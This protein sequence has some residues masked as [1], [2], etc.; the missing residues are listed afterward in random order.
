M[1]TKKGISTALYKL[2][3]GWNPKYTLWAT[4]NGLILA[5][6]GTLEVLDTFYGIDCDGGDP[7]IVRDEDGVERI[8]LGP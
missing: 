2:S 8:M 3:D 5:D 4:P 1:K 7:D 6:A